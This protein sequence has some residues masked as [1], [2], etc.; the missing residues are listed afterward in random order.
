MC[1]Y[2]K[3]LKD[4]L[5]DVVKEQYAVSGWNIEYQCIGD[6]DWLFITKINEQKLD[7]SRFVDIV[8]VFMFWSL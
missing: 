1:G 4:A 3:W 6:D 7:L 5:N 8:C 2:A